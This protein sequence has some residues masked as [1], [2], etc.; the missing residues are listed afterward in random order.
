[1]K[2]FK[3]LP[4]WIIAAAVTGCGVVYTT[5]P[6]GEKP[7]LIE[8]GAWE[9]NWTNGEEYFTVSVLDEA[10]GLLRLAW[11]ERDQNPIKLES[12]NVHLLESGDWVFASIQDKDNSKRYLWGRIKKSDQQAVIWLPDSEKF[13]TL[14]EEG[15]LPGRI[16]DNGILLENLTSKYLKFITSEKAGV[17]FQ[18]DEPIIF[19]RFSD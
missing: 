7:R 16:E 19:R 18:W 3:Y 2:Y 17:L 8:A 5:Q 10:N 15:K 12:C 9:G 4:V 6:I 14:V 1:M 13:K 11:I